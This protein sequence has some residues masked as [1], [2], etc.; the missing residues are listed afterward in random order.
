M[1]RILA[2]RFRGTGEDD[3]DPDIPNLATHDMNVTLAA[4]AYVE[5]QR[6]LEAQ[7]AL[8]EAVNGNDMKKLGDA[9]T[10]AER[11][12]GRSDLMDELIT[13]G[14][15]KLGKSDKYNADGNSSTKPIIITP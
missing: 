14:E 1:R 13:D 7:H 10:K 4:N 8:Q 12:R 15:E 2:R 3:M 6:R 5:K 11:F 9:L